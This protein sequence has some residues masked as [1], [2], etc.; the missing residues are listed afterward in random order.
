[1]AP[2]AATAIRSIGYYIEDSKIA[3][4]RFAPS[5]HYMDGFPYLNRTAADGMKFVYASDNVYYMKWG[6]LNSVAV[7]VGIVAV[8]T[9]VVTGW[10]RP[11][12][13]EG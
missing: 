1:V 4:N 8:M 11:A 3:P 2:G 13:W 6:T 9:A 5:Y 12:F 10:K 7:L